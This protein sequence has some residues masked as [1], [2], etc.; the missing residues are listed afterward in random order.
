MRSERKGIDWGVREKEGSDRKGWD[1][2]VGSERERGLRERGM[3]V[4]SERWE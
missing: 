4:G 3:I 2:R 1:V